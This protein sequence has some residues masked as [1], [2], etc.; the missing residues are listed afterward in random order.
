MYRS[1]ING[2]KIEHLATVKGIY[3]I[4]IAN[5]LI[6]GKISTSNSRGVHT[7]DLD[8]ANEKKIQDLF[9]GVPGDIRVDVE[10]GDIYNSTTIDDVIVKTDIEGEP[11][12]ADDPSYW[13]FNPFNEG[14]LVAC[15]PYAMAIDYKYSKFYYS[16]QSGGSAALYSSALGSDTTVSREKIVDAETGVLNTEY[17]YIV[18]IDIDTEKDKV[19]WMT[20][21]SIQRANLDG[22]EVETIHIDESEA[23][24]SMALS[25]DNQTLYWSE[26]NEI[27]SLKL[28]KAGAKKKLVFKNLYHIHSV[29]TY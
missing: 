22:S 6:Y 5:D 28:N 10:N 11:G 18:K 20:N 12:N 14:C 1:D 13:V 9:T 3:S 8:G 25:S 15:D 29:A 24:F 16:T 17:G 19:Y 26:D 4:D 7:F 2:D 27:Y 23:L 21:M